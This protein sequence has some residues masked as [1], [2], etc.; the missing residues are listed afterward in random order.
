VGGGFAPAFGEARSV[1]LAPYPEY[2]IGPHDLVEIEVYEAPEFRRTVR[3]SP[4]G[5]V[6]LP[7]CQDSIE[8]SGLTYLQAEA[9][10]AQALVDEGLLVGPIVTINIR[11][12]HGNPVQVTGSVRQPVVFPAVGPTTLLDAIARAGGLDTPGREIVITR[13]AQEDRAEETL[14]IPTEEFRGGLNGAQAVPLYG[15]ETVRVVAAERAFLMG[16]IQRPGAIDVVEPE[17]MDFLKLLS[18]AGGL[19]KESNNKAIISFKA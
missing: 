5:T 10:V 15:G 16:A 9:A 18:S 6:R 4:A 1:F 12:A 17:G 2:R 11:E 14:R 8:L 13:P 19:D 7:L 3:V